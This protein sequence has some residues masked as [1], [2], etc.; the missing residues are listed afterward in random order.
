MADPDFI[1]IYCGDF[2]S[3]TLQRKGK[4]LVIGAGVTGLTTALFLKNRGK[5]MEIEIW[6]QETPGHPSRE[7]TS[8]ACASDKVGALLFSVNSGGQSDFR[9]FG[10]DQGMRAS[11]EV[12]AWIELSK[13]VFIGGRNWRLVVPDPNAASNEFRSGSV[14]IASNALPGC[15]HKGSDFA[16][17]FFKHDTEQAQGQTQ[18]SNLLGFEGEAALSN[19]YLIEV[20]IY[21]SWLWSECIREGI[22]FREARFVSAKDVEK[23]RTDDGFDWVINCLG[24]GAE[25]FESQKDDLSR[26]RGQILLVKHGDAKSIDTARISFTETNW[27]SPRLTY[28]IPRSGDVVLGGTYDHCLDAAASDRDTT[29]IL[30]R[31]LELFPDLEDIEKVRRRSRAIVGFWSMRVTESDDNHIDVP[32]RLNKRKNIIHNY[33]HGL[34]GYMMSWG[35][36]YEVARLLDEHM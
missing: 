21:L 26:V 3:L 33:G 34:A 32:V 29:E 6:A 11:G 24:A 28:V 12:R 5:E 27:K 19:C 16:K 18:K 17:R 13:Q 22:K 9:Y 1:S 31:C 20:P 36:A 10:A 4:I 8:S 35:C 7:L 2:E 23:R 14:S 15:T 30:E 25:I